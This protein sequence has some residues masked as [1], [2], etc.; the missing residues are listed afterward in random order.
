MSSEA[1]APARPLSL[2]VGRLADYLELTRPRIASM[3]LLAMVAG[4]WAAADE[5]VDPVLLLHAGLGTWL[6][7][8]G[9]SVLNQVLEKN[10]DGQMHRTRLRPLPDGRVGMTEALVLGLA[11]AGGGCGYLAGRVSRSAALLAGLTCLLYVLIYTPLKRR[12][13]L[14]IVA[15]AIAGALPPVLG[16]A[17][18]GHRLGADA[19]GLFLILFVW[20]FPHF[21]AI[22][23]MLRDDY[24]RAGLCMLPAGD[25]GGQ[26]T[27]RRTVGCCLLL[28]PL[29]VVPWWLGLAGAVYLAGAVLLGLCLLAVACQFAR[30][31]TVPA[32]R[33]LM[34]A[35]V[36]YLPALLTLLVADS[37]PT[38][39]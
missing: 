13:D 36:L 10:T 23:W 18:A 27:A 16:W 12:T 11:L 14:N 22:A 25:R 26:V 33:A 28:V 31:R 19:W 34:R 29:S 37:H 4:F 7:A 20:Q 21:W 39:W 15:G 5:R 3:A 9:S 2:S 38:P 6:V 35:S 24:G 1:A 8:A 30:R 17:A 32:A